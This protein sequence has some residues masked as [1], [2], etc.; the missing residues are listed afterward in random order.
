MGVENNERFK[1]ILININYDVWSMCYVISTFDYMHD[2]YLAVD[3]KKRKRK[4]KKE[5]KS[6]SCKLMPVK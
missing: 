5:T 3:F 1:M 6:T 4:R 2:V